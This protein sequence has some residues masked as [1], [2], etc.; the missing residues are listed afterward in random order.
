MKHHH[1]FTEFERHRS[2]GFVIYRDFDGV[3]LEPS[4]RHVVRPD[5]NDVN[6]SAVFAR[7]VAYPQERGF[8]A[9]DYAICCDVAVYVHEIRLA[10]DVKCD[11]ARHI[12]FPVG[13]KCFAETHETCQ[14]P[15]QQ[16][17]VIGRRSYALNPDSARAFEERDFHENTG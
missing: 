11:V 2:A 1:R 3:E 8:G 9:A 13:Y 7:N 12:Y 14:F 6:C 16:Y 15:R 10:I 5:V 4:H 17:V